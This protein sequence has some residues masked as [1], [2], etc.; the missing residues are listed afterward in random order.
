MSKKN[1]TSHCFGYLEDGREIT[2]WSYTS[3][4]MDVC[5]IDYGASIVHWRVKVAGLW[6]DVIVPCVTAEEAEIS[7]YR[8]ATIGRYANRISQGQFTL[9][10][11]LIQLSRNEGQNHLHGGNEGF[12]RKIWGAECTNDELTLTYL[13][14]DGEEGYPGNLRLDVTFRVINETG[15]EIGYCATS[16][17]DTV[18]NFTNHAYFNLSESD[19]VHD[20]LLH[21]NAI[22]YQPVDN[23][24]IPLNAL[25]TVDGS[26]FD[27]R[28]PR[29][30]REGLEAIDQ[31][32]QLQLGNG[33]DHNYRLLANDDFDV[34][35]AT[36]QSPLGDIV[37]SIYT[38]LPGCQLYTGNHLTP[39]HRALCLETQ[40]FPDS[41]NRP[42]FP[43]TVLKKS[44]TYQ[45]RTRYMLEF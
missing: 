42:D 19:A 21:I 24:L 7:N 16:T 38:T 45:S 13:S 10:D 25:E 9:N 31:D 6:R 20:H 17:K 18:V 36:L 3:E 28:K 12:D 8:A 44:E 41:P 33:Y 34:S 1:F 29:H 14:P 4:K 2:A 32:K 43:S 30:L 35:A 40:H 22:E 11:K 23:E 26:V 5:I 15:I 39:K 27:F 37:L